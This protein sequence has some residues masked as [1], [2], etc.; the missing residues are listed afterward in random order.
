MIA[1]LLVAGNILSLI[2]NHTNHSTFVPMLKRIVQH[3]LPLSPP[4][5]LPVCLSTEMPPGAPM[6][7]K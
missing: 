3:P 7:I 5:G 2:L 1:V 6:L 4:P